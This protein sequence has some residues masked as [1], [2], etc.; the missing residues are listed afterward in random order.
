MASV[1]AL[2]AALR[3]HL[4]PGQVR[5]DIIGIV[6]NIS[7]WLLLVDGERQDAVAELA[8]VRKTL[9]ETMQRLAEQEGCAREP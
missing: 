8:E 5:H 1:K 2:V 9:V 7:S 6:T 4:P 3:E